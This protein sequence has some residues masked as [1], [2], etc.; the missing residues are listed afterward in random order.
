MRGR[1]A[2]TRS[3]CPCP[4]LSC[5][6]E[7]WPSRHR[8]PSLPFPGR[9]AAVLSG[10]LP[11]TGQ[12]P[13][14]AGSVP[15][16][17]PEP[18]RAVKPPAGSGCGTGVSPEVTG[19]RAAVALPAPGPG[20]GG[21]LIVGPSGPPVGPHGLPREHRKEWPWVFRKGPSFPPASRHGRAVWQ[22]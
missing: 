8:P 2:G 16:Q 19:A 11:V 7:A 13:P 3:P 5:R 6:G 21:V 14:V 15:A 4:L 9:S 1:G 12:T 22:L 18:W 17:R 20:G 10:I